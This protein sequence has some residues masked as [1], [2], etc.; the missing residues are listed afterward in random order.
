GTYTFDNGNGSPVTI[1]IPATVVNQFE[2][3]VHGGP[4]NVDGETYNNIEEYFENLIELNETV[5]TL[6]DNGNGTFTYT[7]EEGDLVTFDAN[8]TSFTDN[9]DGTYTF[10]NTNGD[11]ITIDAVND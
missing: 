9:G 10:T 6:V 4:V 5:T 1:D 7:N 2:D 11:T 3:I 8:T